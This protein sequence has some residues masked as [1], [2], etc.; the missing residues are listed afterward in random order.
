MKLN[1]QQISYIENYI[2]KSNVR[3]Y[4][5]YTEI[6][7]HMI[8]SIEALLCKEPISF[9]EAFAKVQAK[10][11]N[12]TE[13]SKISNQVSKIFR[14]RN[15]KSL[16]AHLNNQKK[17]LY[18][19]L[20]VLIFC[21]IFFSKNAFESGILIFCMSSLIHIIDFPFFVNHLFRKKLPLLNTT[22]LMFFYGVF[23][24]TLFAFLAIF[25][26]MLGSYLF[27]DILYYK[28]ML[29]SFFVLF[30]ISFTFNLKQRK[31]IVNEVKQFVK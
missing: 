6:L 9:E 17:P 25:K 3:Y 28:L 23:P 26:T 13:I 16:K 27:V 15:Y 20:N 11:F 7:D 1:Q 30:F 8:L 2:L 31:I 14:E 22:S 5:V 10:D 12:E 19:I 18:L 29:P 4:E 21:F 24:I